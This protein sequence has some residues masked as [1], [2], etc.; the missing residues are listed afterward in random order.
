MKRRLYS[1]RTVL[2]GLGLA[3]AAGMVGFKVTKSFKSATKELLEMPNSERMPAVFIG[4]GSPMNAITENVW[5]SAWRKLGGSL[6]TP[7]AILAISAHWITQGGL[8][9][10]AGEHPPMTYDMGGFPAELYR[11]Q[12]P[13]PGDPALAEEIGQTLRPVIPVHGDI[14]WGYDHGTWVVLKHMFPKANIPVIQLSIDY[15]KPPSYHFELSKQLRSLRDKGVLILGSGNIVHNLRE[16]VRTSDTPFDWALE[17]DRRMND[18]LSDGNY[19][20]IV[21]FQK[22]GTLA[23]IAHPTHDHFLPL[24][25]VLGVQNSGEEVRSLCDGFQYKSVSMRSL[26]VG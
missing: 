1:R 24:L 22:L 7:K 11:I 25:Y 14:K 9:V 6:P 5:T 2:S 17:F 13:A 19:K 26:Q 12:Y 20:A 18:Y 4:H 15:S 21:E 8:L 10:T 16:M 23:A 3:A